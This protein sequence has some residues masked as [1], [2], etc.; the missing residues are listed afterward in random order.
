MHAPSPI[1]CAT[2]LSLAGHG[3]LFLI[4][5]AYTFLPGAADSVPTLT[6]TVSLEDGRDTE[7]QSAPRHPRAIELGP[8]D[9]PITSQTA[10]QRPVE[11]NPD[12]DTGRSN[13]APPPPGE[14]KE[15]AA[16]DAAVAGAPHSRE[17]SEQIVTT[18]GGS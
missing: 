4:F 3:I 13:P 5:G 9:R 7:Q 6:L 2:A 8:T 10:D 1:R 11:I 16:L 18:I 12:D 17:E 14:N 15:A